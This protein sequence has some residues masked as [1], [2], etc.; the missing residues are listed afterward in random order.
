MLSH[1]WFHPSHAD[2]GTPQAILGSSCG[3]LHPVLFYPHI[4]IFSQMPVWFWV[5]EGLCSTPPG[6]LYLSYIHHILSM[7]C[8]LYVWSPSQL[9]AQAPEAQLPID[10]DERVLIKTYL[11]HKQYYN[12]NSCFWSHTLTLQHTYTHKNTHSHTDTHTFTLTVFRESTCIWMRII[13]ETT[14][15]YTSK[16]VDMSTVLKN[17]L[18]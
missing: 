6:C 8:S 17:I 10:T 9:S 4:D 11:A 5:N 15:A 12:M 2:R 16:G 14:P 7:E 18:Q 13:G 1:G 3:H